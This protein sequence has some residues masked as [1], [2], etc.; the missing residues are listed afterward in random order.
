MTVA[1]DAE[2]SGGS[3]TC[4]SAQPE[5]DDPQV[6]GV[7]EPGPDGRRLSYVNGHVPVT[8]EV[9]AST[10][11]VPP[12]LVY[13][14]AARC[15]ESRCRH[16]DGARCGLALRMVEGLQPT[17]EKLPPCAIRRT[18]RW[19]AEAGDAACLRCSQVVT[20]IEDAT[21]EIAEI[22]RPGSV[23]ATG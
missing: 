23:T 19:H 3:L 18:C 2:V 14:F 17:V 20:W 11:D 12:T 10:G 16:F 22:V 13:R 21:P 8:E 6:I 9:L 1:D 15:M 4:P 5:M 7:M